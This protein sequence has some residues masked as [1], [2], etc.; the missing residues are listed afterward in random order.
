MKS[1]TKQQIGNINGEPISINPKN[2]HYTEYIDD[3]LEVNQ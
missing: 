2:A 1:N 3:V